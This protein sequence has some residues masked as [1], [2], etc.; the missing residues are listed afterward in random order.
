MRA[1]ETITAF[2]GRHAG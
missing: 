2:I 1:M